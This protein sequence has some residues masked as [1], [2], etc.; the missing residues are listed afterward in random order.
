M[1][2]KKHRCRIC[3][4]DRPNNGTICLG[5]GTALIKCQETRKK[6]PV[7]ECPGCRSNGP[8]KSIE[9]GRFRCPKCTAVF[10][11]GDFGFLDDRP[12]INVEKKERLEMELRKGRR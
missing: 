6:K 4:G 3:L 5:C 9:A 1:T 7:T 8:F 2:T 12:D 10:E 11:S